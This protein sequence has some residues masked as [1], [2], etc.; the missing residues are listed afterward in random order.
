MH[1]IRHD[2]SRHHLYPEILFFLSGGIRDITA[3]KL[4]ELVGLNWEEMF[5]GIN[6]DTAF[7]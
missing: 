5:M 1:I 4:V 3:G 2:I 7:L 6:T